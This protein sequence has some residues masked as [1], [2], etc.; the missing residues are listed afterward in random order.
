MK[1]KPKQFSELLDRKPVGMTTTNTTFKNKKPTDR[2]SRIQIVLASEVS[3]EKYFRYWMRFIGTDFY[4][5]RTGETLTKGEFYRRYPEQAESLA[6]NNAVLS[7]S[8][9]LVEK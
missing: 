7:S 3:N 8:F 6:D 4:V 1:T 5:K 9:E 2:A